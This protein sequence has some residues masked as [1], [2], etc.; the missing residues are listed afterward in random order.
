MTETALFLQMDVEAA[1]GSQRLP[2]T[3]YDAAT[4]LVKG[5]V[6]VAFSKIA[7]KLESG[8]AEGIAV[9]H[10]AKEVASDGTEGAA[11]KLLHLISL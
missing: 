1:V 8:E 4:E 7:Y 2:V 11:S 5:H 10:V 9:N 6:E 3:I